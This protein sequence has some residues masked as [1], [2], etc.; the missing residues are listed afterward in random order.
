MVERETSIPQWMQ[1]LQSAAG[2]TTSPWR[3]AVTSPKNP[4]DV[5]THKTHE[6]PDIDPFEINRKE[7]RPACEEQDRKTRT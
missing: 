3:L 1:W 5:I 2:T 4:F 6:N 7:N